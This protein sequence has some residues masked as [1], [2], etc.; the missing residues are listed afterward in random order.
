MQDELLAS[1]ERERIT[2]AGTLAVLAV[3]FAGFVCLG[4][5]DG[6]MG[7]AWPSY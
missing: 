5:P 4:L 7:V 3:S 1:R 2:S 6:T